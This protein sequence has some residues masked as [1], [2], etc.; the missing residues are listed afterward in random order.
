[1]SGIACLRQLSC[2]V[3]TLLSE[4]PEEIR[5]FRVNPWPFQQTFKTPLKELN[6]FVTTFLAPFSLE[7]GAMSTDEVVFEPKDLLQLLAN[8]SLLVQDQHHLTIQAEGQQAVANLLQAAL[9]DW[10]DFVFVPTPEVLAIYADHDEY[11][12]FYTRDEAIL[13]NVVSSLEKS[14]FEIVLDYTRGFSGGKWR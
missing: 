7:K 3:L 6:R 5:R 11:T 14:G 1:L 12:T 13:K 2:T 8:N 9:G 4:R 10:V